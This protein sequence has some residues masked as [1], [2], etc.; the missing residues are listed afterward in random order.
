[1]GQIYIAYRRDDAAAISGRVADRLRARFGAHAVLKDVEAG[2]TQGGVAEAVRQCSAMVVII[3]P[4]WLSGMLAAPLDQTHIEI[5]SAL[6]RGVPVIPTLVHGATLPDARLLPPALWP[7]VTRGSVILGPEPVFDRDTAYLGDMLQ[8]FM[9]FGGYQPLTRTR[10]APVLPGEVGAQAQRATL[11]W[12]ALGVA[13]TLAT[14][15]VSCGGGGVLLAQSRSTATA[16]SIPD[17]ARLFDIANPPG[18]DDVW[19]V[20]GNASSCVLLHYAG[21]VWS[22]A[23]CP[24]SAELDSVS[25]VNSGEGWAVGGLMDE[26]C[27]LLHYHGGSWSPVSCPVSRFSAEPTVRMDARGG[28]W[29]TGGEATLRYVNDLWT[30]YSGPTPPLGL[31]MLAVSGQG[32]AWA[33]GDGSFHEAIDGVW[34]VVQTPHINS[35]AFF[36]SMDFSREGDQGWAVGYIGLRQRAYIAAYRAGQWQ[37]YAPAPSVGELNLVRIGL[38]GDVWASGGILNPATFATSGLLMR[39]DGQ[40]WKTLGDPINGSIYGITDV[41]NGDA[42]AVGTNDDNAALLWYH[43]GF[44]RIY[45]T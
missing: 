28:G 13:L 8:R 29:I 30:V 19:A 45:H 35:S 40:G 22:R 6:R 9:P 38:F 3:G 41:P 14:L 34:T 39:Y 18:T 15:I 5:E 36:E 2:E 21:G 42:W 43:N 4:R 25:F 27:R 24:F 23:S 44:W 11:G 33:A 12:R 20:G 16:F 1:M 32:D 31:R 37:P 7:L 17:R 26:H 10:R